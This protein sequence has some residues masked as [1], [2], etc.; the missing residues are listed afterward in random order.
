ML[1]FLEWYVWYKTYE[2]YL[3]PLVVVVALAFVRWGGGKTVNGV[4]SLGCAIINRYVAYRRPRE[5]SDELVKL[6]TMLGLA[7]KLRDQES[8]RFG[9]RTF[10]DDGRVYVE[11]RV[12]KG[13][14]DIEVPLEK[15]EK[16]VLATKFTD[17]RKE[18][19]AKHVANIR[20]AAACGATDLQENGDIIE[21]KPK[22][23]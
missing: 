14:E 18:L 19:D 2:L 8:L 12:A 17:R 21:T 1:G 23:G 13:L 7:I 22:K 16:T 10:F 4:R 3:A 20:L 5:H 9:G 11:V 15:W 6:I